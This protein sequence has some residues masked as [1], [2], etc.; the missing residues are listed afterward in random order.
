MTVTLTVGKPMVAS[1]VPPLRVSE[2]EPLTAAAAAVPGRCQSPE[3]AGGVIEGRGVA[4]T[5]AAGG[6]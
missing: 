4:A 3:R 2:T 6:P 5:E 1:L